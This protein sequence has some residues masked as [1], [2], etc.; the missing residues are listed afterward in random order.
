M[1]S[2]AELLAVI[3]TNFFDWESKGHQRGALDLLDK[4]VSKSN[5]HL[6]AY[7]YRKLL[8]KTQPYYIIVCKQPQNEFATKAPQEYIELIPILF[9]TKAEAKIAAQNGGIPES[10]IH[11]LFEPYIIQEI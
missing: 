2:E 6:L 1:L 7:V 3:K 10:H 4:L 11:L 5:P 8:G 9:E